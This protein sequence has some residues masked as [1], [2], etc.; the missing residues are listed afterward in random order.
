MTK[1]KFILYFPN[2]DTIDSYSKGEPLFDYYD[3]AVDMALEWIGG[4][5]LGGEILHLSNPG[6]YDE[7]DEDEKIEYDIEEVEV[8]E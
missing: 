5:R 1:Y 8:D 7:P 3:A 4:Y 6:D 2:G